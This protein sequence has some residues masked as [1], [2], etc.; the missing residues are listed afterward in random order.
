M[1]WRDEQMEQ[2][3]GSASRKE[4]D[5]IYRLIV[6]RSRGWTEIWKFAFLSKFLEWSFSA[7][8]TDYHL[9]F[10]TNTST[11]IHRGNEPVQGK[12]KGESRVRSQ[13]LQVALQFGAGGQ[14][15]S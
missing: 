2:M 5:K 14:S 3:R 10:T 6:S 8:L 13:K 15:G 12:R 4:I 1:E 11:Y 9:D 7:L